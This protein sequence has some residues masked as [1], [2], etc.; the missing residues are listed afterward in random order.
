MK[1]L[2]M[3]FVVFFCLLFFFTCQVYIITERQK[4]AKYIMKQNDSLKNKT[5]NYGNVHLVIQA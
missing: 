4:D 3:F 1:Y 5:N 2:I